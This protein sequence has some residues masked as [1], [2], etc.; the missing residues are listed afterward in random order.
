VSGVGRVVRF[1]GPALGAVAAAAVGAVA[2]GRATG[3]TWLVV[4]GGLGG[5]A[6]GAA[7]VAVWLAYDRSGIRSWTWLPE[8]LGRPPG[9]WA[10]VHVGY[11]DGGR[12]LR[13]VLGEPAAALDVSPGV[14]H[15]PA[16]QRRARRLFPSDAVPSMP[17]RLPLADGRTDVALLPYSA[18]EVRDP[19]AR[20]ALFASLA[21]AVAPDGRLVLVEHHRDWRNVLAFGPAAWHFTRGTEW[22]ATIAAAGFDVVDRRRLA[23][24]VTATVARRTAP[25]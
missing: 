11:D 9:R 1:N 3:A 21:R 17:D 20:A 4:V 23:G 19:A 15:L 7:L 5:A 12:P 22:D 18:H 14:G 13:D 25:A 2:L 8:L 10:L 16:S 24:L 6:L